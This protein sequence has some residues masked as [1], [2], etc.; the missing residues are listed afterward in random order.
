[1]QKIFNKN[2]LKIALEFLI[3]MGVISLILNI[4]AISTALAA[5]LPVSEEA[6]EFI[7]GQNIPVPPKDMEG[8]NALIMLAMGALS[9]GKVIIGAIGILF[10][11]ILGIKL[12]FAGSNEED[13]TKAKTGIIYIIV[14]F[15]L[16]SMSQDIAKIFDMGDKTLLS[17]PQEMLN[18]VHLFDKQIEIVM[19]FIKYV[20]G[21][22]ATIMIIRSA[23]KLITAGGN[24]EEVGKQRKSILFHL[25][26]LVLIFVGDV[27]INKVFY[28]VDK[29]VYSGIT[30][31]HPGVD[32]KAGVEQIAGI[33]NF[34]VSFVGPAAVLL[35]IG[36]AIMYAVSGGEEEKMNKAKRLLIATVI[37][38]IIVYSAFAV[39][40]TLLNSKLAQIGA[41]VE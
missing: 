2:I 20:I 9:Y 32:A 40:S 36:G 38:I 3:V 18:R 30:G 37:G 12:I 28:K 34:I 39:V 41:L 33:T 16:V 5:Y 35:L 11:T 15:V 26:G 22:F 13:I 4:G 1:M 6:K 31:V 17:S 8:Q 7:K 24:E 21:A 19:T 27:F 29:N 14:A 23:A 10:I 25:A